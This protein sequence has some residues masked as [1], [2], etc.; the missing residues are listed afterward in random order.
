VVCVSIVLCLEGGLRCKGDKHTLRFPL[1]VKAFL[2][3]QS[4]KPSGLSTP[5]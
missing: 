5:S 3:F 1:A 4:G 2:Q